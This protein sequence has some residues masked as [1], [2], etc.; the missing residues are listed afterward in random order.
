M[1]KTLDLWLLRLCD[2]KLSSL[3]TAAL[4]LGESACLLDGF[5]QGPKARSLSKSDPSSSVSR[6]RTGDQV[7]LKDSNNTLV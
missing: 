3:L 5:K 2:E 4:G 7:K 1:G 6:G